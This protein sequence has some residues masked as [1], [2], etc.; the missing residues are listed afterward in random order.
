ML[1]FAETRGLVS[2]MEYIGIN[3]YGSHF[4]PS[5]NRNPGQDELEGNGSMI[6]ESS[7]LPD[8]DQWW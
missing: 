7:R 1:H 2:L 6:W 8:M 4:D 3:I 5:N